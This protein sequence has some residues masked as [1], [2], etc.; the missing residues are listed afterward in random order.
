MAGL[1]PYY[2]TKYNT[3]AFYGWSEKSESDRARL[4]LTE[5][6]WKNCANYTNRSFDE[7][8]KYME[9]PNPYL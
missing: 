2:K 5:K 8:V 7:K 3:C 1:C 4:C 9:R 6:N